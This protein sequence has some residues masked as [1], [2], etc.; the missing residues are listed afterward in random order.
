[1]ANHESSRADSDT[2][3][4]KDGGK[5]VYDEN[6][7]RIRL[8]VT[9][10]QIKSAE[11]EMRRSMTEKVKIKER[12]DILKG[13]DDELIKGGAK[14]MRDGDNPFL[15]VTAEQIEQAKQ[16][17]SAFLEKVDKEK[18]ERLVVAKELE[19]SLHNLLKA[20]NEKSARRINEAVLNLTA[21]VDINFYLMETSFSQLE[22]DH[23]L[24]RVRKWVYGEEIPIIGWRHDV[25]GNE[26]KARPILL[27][28]E[29][30]LSDHECKVALNVA[31]VL[32]QMADSWSCLQVQ[33]QNGQVTCPNCERRKH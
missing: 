9:N 25:P 27:P 21:L 24:D 16:E 29:E 33:R 8:E 14:R 22:F 20:L 32:R 6:L 3:I 19:K 23:F 2:E 12:E 7:K 4:I 26:K 13:H 1:M 28:I 11:Q 18:T 31:Y 5:M 15:V 17:M 10:D 30:V